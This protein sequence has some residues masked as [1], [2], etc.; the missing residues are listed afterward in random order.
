[1]YEY[2]IIIYN[3]VSCYTII[4]ISDVTLKDHLGM[5]LIDRL[6]VSHRVRNRS[7]FSILH[8]VDLVYCEQ[9]FSV[10]AHV[11]QDSR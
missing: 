10:L 8:R 6:C 9:A 2:I 5:I 11:T 1:M 7:T 3:I 4:I